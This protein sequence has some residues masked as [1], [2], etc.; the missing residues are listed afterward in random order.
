MNTISLREPSTI[1][2]PLLAAGAQ[3]LQSVLVSLGLPPTRIHTH[4]HAHTENKHPWLFLSLIQTY[5]DPPKCSHE[6]S[7]ETNIPLKPNLG[8]GEVEGQRDRERET[9]APGPFL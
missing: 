1:Q 9:E 3:C 8:D 5:L 7:S 6:N 2:D 4:K